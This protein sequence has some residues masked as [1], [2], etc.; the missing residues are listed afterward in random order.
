M[1]QPEPAPTPGR[2]RRW[3]FT[4]LMLLLPVLFFALV[5]GGLRLFGYGASLPLFV[6]AEGAGAGY[7]Y[8]N[9]DVARRYF[10]H[11]Q[12]VPTS[13]LDFF[14]DQKSPRAFRIFV[15]GGSTAAGFPFYYGGAFSRMLGQRLQ[16]TFPDRPIEVVNTAMAA[17]NSYTLL[18]LAGE[19]IAQQPDAILIY[20]GHNE[21]YGALGVGS[22]ETLGR[23]PGLVRFYLKLQKLRTVQL[24]RALIA[25]AM[26]AGR[27]AAAEQGGTLM[28]RVVGE[29]TIPYGSPLYR[30]GLRQFA[31]N[32]DAL[33]A[34]YERAGIPVFV[35]TIASNERDQPPFVSV[36]ERGHGAGWTARVERLAALPGSAA[37]DSLRA[38]VARDSLDALAPYRL[39]QRLERAGDTLAAGPYYRLARD[40]DA[41]RFRA[42]EEVNATIRRVA[43]QHGATVVEAAEAL[44]ARSPGGTVGRA[45]ILEHLHPT[46]EGYFTIADAFY[47][48]LRKAGAIGPWTNA[49]DA[50]AARREVALTPLDSL[51]GMYRVAQLKAAWP[52]QPP[53]T[54]RPFLD[55][56]AAQSPIEKLALRLFL[57]KT[58]WAAANQAQ[59]DYFNET[60]DVRHAVQAARALDQEAP[61][62]PDGLLA[63][64]SA[65]MAAGRFGEAL[66]YFQRANVRRETA[67][68]R[69]MEGAILLN[70]GATP[71]AIRALTRALALDP[72]DVQARYNLAGAYAL[73][74]DYAAARAA[75]AEVLAR[76][77]GHPGAQQLLSQLSAQ[78]R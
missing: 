62:S 47:D 58:T 12:N 63:A 78:A 30:A 66:P 54:T 55:T 18:D 60:G 1:K 31:S 27:P 22:T 7:R 33:L 6:E 45:M 51:V 4:A 67:V 36:Q 5:E 53:G 25:R 70:A 34:K 76:D 20:A 74:G 50:A 73:A 26:A 3:V 65:F 14:P 10:Y 9:R 41:L 24:L 72:A 40:R 44:R 2:R 23:S 42:S 13:L 39:A 29:Q 77:P 8:Q 64:G 59:L 46:V 48:A 43:A 15:Q 35:A 69:S 19:I 57:G 38:L 21:F 49:V 37:R 71:E 28:A 56:L 32:L 61:Y 52:F 17:V 68:G 11:Q 75:T 16:E